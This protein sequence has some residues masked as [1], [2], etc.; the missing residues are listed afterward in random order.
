MLSTFIRAFANLRTDRNRNRYPAFTNHRAPHKPL[1]LLSM[2]DLLAQ[3]QIMSSF[4]E[5][6]LE[7]VETFN[8]AGSQ[9]FDKQKKFGNK[10]MKE[11]YN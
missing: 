5:P 1:L 9:C 6:S 11:I 2:M 4:I 8:V 7:L 3:G 10:P